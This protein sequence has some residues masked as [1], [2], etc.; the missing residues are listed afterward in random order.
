[1]VIWGGFGT[2][3]MNTG[4]LYD[5]VARSW[6]PTTTTGAPSVRTL[7]TAVWTGSR[8]IVWG[9]QDAAGDLNNG[10]RYDPVGLTW[11]SMTSA[12]APSP[13][14]S[15]HAVWA[16]GFMLAWGG[17]DSAGALATGGRYALGQNADADHDG[18]RVC[19]GD[20][21]DT[22]SAVWSAPGEATDLIFLI[23]AAPGQTTLI[24]NAPNDAG[25]TAPLSYD[26]LRATV[27]ADFGAA[28]ALCLETADGSDTSA[29]DTGSL[30]AGACFFYLV[31]A[32]NACPAVVGPLGADSTG[33]WRTGRP[34]P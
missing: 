18:V 25:G 16:N 20:C 14:D 6:A 33:A 28:A 34:C 30:G 19:A 27:A 15:H 26:T 10:G 24:W 12:G 1:M 21:D 9:G 31:R 22:N 13:R 11:Q 2:A 29:V 23:P 3:P 4:G 32:R 8:M 7:H 5:P 17:Q